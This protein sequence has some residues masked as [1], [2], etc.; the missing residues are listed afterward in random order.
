M[1][2]F[3]DA[4]S[5][6]F[7]AVA[8]DGARTLP[9]DVFGGL[10]EMDV[11][12]GAWTNSYRP[13]WLAAHEAGQD[14]VVAVDGSTSQVAHAA[15]PREQAIAAVRAFRSNPSPTGAETV[16]ALKAVVAFLEASRF[17]Q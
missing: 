11:S 13:A 4:T 16:A 17:T 2:L 5:R 9:D 12:D 8:P 6:V 10:L 15:T 3:L 1:R 14:L 7:K